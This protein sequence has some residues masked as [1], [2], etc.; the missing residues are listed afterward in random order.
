MA[1]TPLDIPRTWVEFPD[2][3]DAG[4]RAQAARTAHFGRRVAVRPAPPHAAPTIAALVRGAEVLVDEPGILGHVSP[5]SD[6][7]PGWPDP[8]I[9]TRQLRQAP[10]GASRSS[11]HSAG[12]STPIRRSA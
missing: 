7:D 10:V 8:A 9:S 6:G 4:R 3:A 5:D 11:S 1:E 2:P 12:T